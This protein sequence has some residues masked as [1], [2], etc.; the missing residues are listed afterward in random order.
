MPCYDERSS[1]PYIHAEYQE[2]LDKLTRLLCEANKIIERLA[3]E[4]PVQRS[5]ELF[6][7]WYAH[8]EFDKRRKR[9]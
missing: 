6:T 7:W 8:K 3:G 9:K 5:Q 4:R 1:A 2:K